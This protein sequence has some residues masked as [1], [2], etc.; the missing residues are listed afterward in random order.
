M[1]VSSYT[2]R[3]SNEGKLSVCALFM[4]LGRNN[5]RSMHEIPI[6]NPPFTT[7]PL[8]ILNGWP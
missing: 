1:R 7:P 3:Q 2:A 8:R 6:L 4:A 5:T